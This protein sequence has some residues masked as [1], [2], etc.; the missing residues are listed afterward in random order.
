MSKLPLY[1]VT[2][3]KG[4]GKTTVIEELRKLM[5]EYVI[6]DYDNVIEFIKDDFGKFDTHQLLNIWLRVARDIAESGRK[7]IICGIIWPHDIERC[8]DFN[9]FK[10]VYYLALH[11]DDK[12]REIR[13]RKR[14]NTTKEKLLKNNDFAKWF[15]E[16]ADKYNPPIPIIDTSKTDA[17]KV[18]QQISE[19]IHGLEKNKNSL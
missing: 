10:H 19:W 14:K 13:L 18:A 15:I 16:I 12:T 8:I 6:F 17:T 4:T 3:A 1:V 11:C 9:D 7:T 5:P 2:G